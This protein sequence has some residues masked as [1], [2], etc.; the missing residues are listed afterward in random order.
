MKPTR[1]TKA[2]L[3][4]LQAAQSAK[5]GRKLA[6]LAVVKDRATE[7]LRAEYRATRRARG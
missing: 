7:A 2:W 3:A 1:A 4:A 6:T 5:Y